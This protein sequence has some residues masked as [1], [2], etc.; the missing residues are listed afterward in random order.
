MRVAITGSSG[1]V[2]SHLARSLRVEGVSVVP[3]SRRAGVDIHDVEGLAR[4][5]SG[6]GSVAH[7]A[8]INRETE[9]QT[10]RAAHVDGTRSVV[11][12]ARRAGVRKVVLLSF[13]GARAAARSRYH[14]SK[15]EA[16]EEVRASG[17]D[18]T[19]VKAGVI[20]GRGDQM[21]DHLSH[22]LHTLPLFA[23]VGVRE[24]PIRPIPIQDLVPILRAALVGGL[25]S[26]Q[27]VA[28]AGAEKLLLSEA[29]RRVARV[30]DR[31]VLVVPSPVLA[32]YGFAQLLEWTMTVPLVAKAQVRMLSEG[33]VEPAT[34]CDPLPRSLQP[35]RGMTEELIRSGLP[36][37]G[38][39]KMRDLK[40]CAR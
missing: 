16:E 11:E 21:L 38:G 39:F 13:L 18:H 32:Q 23:T 7:C 4:A 9:S 29:V 22:S 3:V 17:L 37:A 12:A 31:R 28:A 19:I 25:L 26:G 33:V 30:L 27:T 24:K 40:F 8:G 15:W 6:C 2:G 14:L 10:F 36:P 20:Y 1:F 34:P 5:F 35:K